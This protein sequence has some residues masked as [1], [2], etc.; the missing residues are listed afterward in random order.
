MERGIRL[1]GFSFGQRAFLLLS[2]ARHKLPSYKST[3]L[4]GRTFI[5]GRH[6]PPRYTHTHRTSGIALYYPRSTPSEAPNGVHAMRSM[7]K[8][9]Q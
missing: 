6:R 5:S 4:V 1:M 7:T 2:N 3:G 9:R 8:H